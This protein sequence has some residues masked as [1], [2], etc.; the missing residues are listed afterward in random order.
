MTYNTREELC[1]ILKGLQSEPASYFC[2]S[3]SY[4]E[5][6]D[7]NGYD[8]D[9]DYC[10]EHDG[11]VLSVE[12]HISGSG[13][14][15]GVTVCLGTGGPHLELDTRYNLLIGYWGSETVKLP[16]DAD[17]CREVRNF[18]ESLHIC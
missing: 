10:D 1:K 12:H 11:G 17:K 13:S 7:C 3:D 15:N 18:W 5:E 2:Y 4:C 6:V 14:Y 9:G 16:M 8:E